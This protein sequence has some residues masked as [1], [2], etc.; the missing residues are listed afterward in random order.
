MFSFFTANKS[1]S[2]SNLSS[3]APP[4]VEETKSSF[5]FMGGGIGGEAP[6]PEPASEAGSGECPFRPSLQSLE[7]FSIFN[8]CVVM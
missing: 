4:E 1:P 6:A 3:Q 5:S 7:N 2:N 8:N